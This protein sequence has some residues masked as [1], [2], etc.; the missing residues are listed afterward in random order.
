MKDRDSEEHVLLVF[1]KEREAK[2][3]EEVDSRTEW[4][5]GGERVDSGVREV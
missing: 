1:E 5:E 3:V 4:L 2:R